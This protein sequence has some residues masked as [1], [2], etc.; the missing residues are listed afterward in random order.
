MGTE[1]SF[2]SSANTHVIIMLISVLISC[3]VLFK[4]A[5]KPHY[6]LRLMFIG[7]LNVFFY[8]ALA[9]YKLLCGTG[10]PLFQWLLPLLFSLALI[11]TVQKRIIMYSSVLF[12]SLLALF[13]CHHYFYLVCTDIYMDSKSKNTQS[14][15]NAIR[16]E[17]VKQNLAIK[18]DYLLK[19]FEGGWLNDV[20]G[21]NNLKINKRNIALD[22]MYE[23]QATRL[24]HT[25]LTN[26]VLIDKKPV[27]I[28]YPGGLFKKS[29]KRIKF[30]PKMS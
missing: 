4:Y 15:Q 22:E 1:L 25:F 20:I 8:I 19:S 3:Y 13:L 10:S 29:Y 17:A 21:Q 7:S 30:K 27:G 16:L 12:L 23:F 24:W 14:L 2:L 6:S 18:E 9:N 26:L 5:E 11:I 28:W